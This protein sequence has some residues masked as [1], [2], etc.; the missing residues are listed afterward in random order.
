MLAGI[1]RTKITPFPGVE[2]AGWGY[3][4][5]RAWRQIHD[6]LF[7]TALVVEH[8]D[9]AV[10]VVALDLMVIDE[11][12]TRLTRERIS[13][14]TGIPA[15]S[16][17]LTCSHSHNAPAAGGLLGVGECDRD[18]EDQTARLAA[19]AAIEAWNART[20]AR[21]R[22]G[23]TTVDDVSYN[24]TRP[25]G[26]IDPTL[27]AAL[28]ERSD[29]TP[30]AAIMN[31][32]AH[33]TVT[34]ELRPWHVSRDVPGRVCDLLE[35]QFPGVTT[36]YIQGAC[37]DVNFLPE[38][39]TAERCD[40]P[41]RRLA[42]VAFDVLKSAA[43]SDNTAVATVSRIT[44]LPTRR[45]LREEIDRDRSEASRRIAEQDFSNW[46]ATIGRCMTNRPDDMVT[47]HGGNEAKAVRA[48]CRFQMEWTNLM[49][50]DLDSRPAVLSTEVQAVRIGPLTIV[51][52]STEFFSPFARE[53]R[54][55]AE[56]PQLMIACYS[57]GRIG[58]L[59]DAYDINAKSYAGYQSPKYCNQ[60]PFTA[61]SG[62]AM[63]QAMVN[64]IEEVSS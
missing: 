16:V 62:P 43:V 38:F 59:P 50:R 48:M 21:I 64:V 19:G 52:N 34:T 4:I 29:G 1:S 20:P 23:T 60:F 22:C 30:L 45:W 6:D 35:Q 26:I 17:L 14:A 57:N 12:F 53:V 39:Q 47:R 37:G 28:I 46:K 44:E 36:M 40:Q 55:N 13:D 51:A 41:A 7:A 10:I 33:P 5:E 31:F 63:C 25:N 15:S 27:T 56:A 24:R 11:R 9:S 49:L 42:D 3:Y 54:R 2:L 32:G 61:D 8:D 18:Y 58:Y